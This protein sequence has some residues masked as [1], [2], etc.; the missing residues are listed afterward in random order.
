[1]RSIFF[2]LLL[3]FSLI[4]LLAG[5]ISSLIMLSFSRRSVDS[6]RRD[7]MQQLQSSIARSVVLMGQSAYVIHQY[8][9]EPAFAAYVKEIQSS[10]RT[11]L[12]LSIDNTIVPEEPALDPAIVHLAASA[13][14]GI[15][16]IIQD[17]GRELLV[18]Q[19]LTTPEGQPYTVIGLHRL[20]PPP[21]MERPPPPR[22]GLGQGF[23]PPPNQE[24]FFTPLGRVQE[25]RLLVFLPV[26]GVIC[27]LLARSF[28]APLARLR[29]ISRQIA[30]GD[31]SARVGTSLGKPGNEIGDLARDFDH[32]A[33]RMEGLV[34]GQKR[35]LLDISHELRSPL[36][37]LNLALE[38]AKKRFPE[39]DG[40]LDRIARESERL[41]VLIGQLLALTRSEALAIDAD[42]SPV[43]LADLLLEIAEDVN[44][45][46]Q[47][48]GKGV[49]I[50][51]L[52]TMVVAG[53]RELLRQA[54]ENIVRNGAYY[55]RP[56]SRVEISL[57]SR[58]TEV[59]GR[60]AVIRIRDHG[61]GVPEDKLPH[62]TE[63]FYRVAEA[64][65]RN[66]GGTGLGL[67]I[68]GQAVLQHGGTILFA[69]A[70]DR[71][72]LIVDIL[73]PIKE[74]SAATG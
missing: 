44:F 28:S 67:A 3:T 38:L 2:R 40:N 16:P 22:E 54:I 42:S 65:D 25:L 14:E 68:A 24:V 63:P 4:I 39:E 9:G 45:E 1:M 64:R 73:L 15:P 26:A 72:G 46:N 34:N 48:R 13:A 17:D 10:V 23:P 11:R 59:G 60:L 62:L 70:P 6:F 33:E 51:E 49:S 56:E 50:L 18:I 71:D 19:R 31:L 43:H 55:T 37:R 69:N 27:Y 47:N 20:G 5:L 41:N 53:S 52:E 36:T 66:S 7:F 74:E 32:M 57:S 21:G 61:P 35:L 12:Y 58:E 8:R 29:R 30:A